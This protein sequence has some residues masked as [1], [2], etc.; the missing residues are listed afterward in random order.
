MAP[1]LNTLRAFR[2][3]RLLKS[4]AG[5]AFVRGYYRYSPPVAKFMEQK[6]VLR[7]VIRQALRPLIWLAERTTKR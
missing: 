7:W 1:E 3:E 2:D 6:P 4:E 5:Q